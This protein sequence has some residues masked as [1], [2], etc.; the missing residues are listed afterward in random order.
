MACRRGRVRWSN[1]PRARSLSMNGRA[2]GCSGVRWPAD[3]RGD[4][5]TSESARGS[6][7]AHRTEAATRSERGVLRRRP[8]PDGIV[9]VHARNVS[10]T[11][12]GW[13][14]WRAGVACRV[15]CRTSPRGGGGWRAGGVPDIAAGGGVP[16]AAGGW[17]AGWR[18]G[19]R[20]GV[21]CRGFARASSGVDFARDAS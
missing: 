17:R 13:R 8:A 4:D 2:E 14:G 1:V 12:V 5:L 10:L 9:T 18:A 20:R 11:G 19:H 3:V 15:A 16:G 6:P 7:D 21:A